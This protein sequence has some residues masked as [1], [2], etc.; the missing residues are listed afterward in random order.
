MHKGKWYPPAK[1][2]CKNITFYSSTLLFKIPK[3]TCYSEV[4]KDKFIWTSCLFFCVFSSLKTFSDWFISECY[5][6]VN[7]RKFLWRADRSWFLDK[8]WKTWK[9]GHFE[10]MGCKKLSKGYFHSTREKRNILTNRFLQ[11]GRSLPWCIYGF[12][13]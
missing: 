13:G 7:I 3:I 10:G 8:C 6:S 4:P 5:D 1:S 2:V 11:E 12:T 9:L